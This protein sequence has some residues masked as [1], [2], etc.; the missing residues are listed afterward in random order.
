MQALECKTKA[1]YG[2]ECSASTGAIPDKTSRQATIADSRHSE[3]RATAQCE[4]NCGWEEAA[5]RSSSQS[6]ERDAT[7]GWRSTCAAAGVAQMMC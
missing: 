1:R 5:L 6:A 7:V 2:Y 4:S 3:W